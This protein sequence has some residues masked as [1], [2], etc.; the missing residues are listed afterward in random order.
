MQ[1]KFSTPSV[2]KKKATASRT[3]KVNNQHKTSTAKKGR[4]RPIRAHTVRSRRGHGE[5]AGPLPFWPPAPLPHRP[6][7]QHTLLSCQ[8]FALCVQSNSLFLQKKQIN[9][10]G[11]RKEGVTRSEGSE[12][13]KSFVY[14]AGRMLF[15]LPIANHN[16][17]NVSAKA[18]DYTFKTA[19]LAWRQTDGLSQVFHLLLG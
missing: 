17:C 9:K 12:F 14:L 11:G 4:L 19:L 15:I 2:K 6:Q 3:E 8:T 7:L 18:G 5:V 13:R 16:I 10:G 1:S